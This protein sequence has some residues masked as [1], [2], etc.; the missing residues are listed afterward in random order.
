MH[1]DD[2]LD[3]ECSRCFLYLGGQLHFIQIVLVNKALTSSHVLVDSSRIFSAR[4]RLMGIKLVSE[5]KHLSFVEFCKSLLEILPDLLHF[6]LGHFRQLERLDGCRER[7]LRQRE[8]LQLL[9]A[10][11]LLVGD[12][13]CAQ[14]FIRSL[15]LLL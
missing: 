10:I 7:G 5:R 9:V 8:F 1:V 13:G 11:N 2:P 3:E 15:N 4:Q 14:C 12:L 6:G